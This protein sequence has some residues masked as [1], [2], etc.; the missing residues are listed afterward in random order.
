MQLPEEIRKSVFFV[1]YLTENGYKFAG[2]G[3]FVSMSLA[4]DP[5]RMFVYLITAKHVIV[6]ATRACIDGKIW[7][8]INTKN[9][10]E[11]VA[12]EETS[13]Q[14]HPED[15]SIDAAVLSWAPDSAYFDYLTI[16][17]SLIINEEVIS[18][19]GIGLG[20]EVFLIGLFVNHHGRKKNIPI[21][22]FGNIAAMPEEPIATRWFGDMEAYLI[23]ARSIGGLSGSPVFV[24]LPGVRVR[25]NGLGMGGRAFYWLGLMHGH[26]DL[27][28]LKEDMVVEDNI[29][30]EA[31]NMG[32]GIVV[33]ASKI[34]EIINS[35]FFM[36][37]RE[38]EISKL[39]GSLED[40]KMKALDVKIETA[41]ASK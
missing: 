31:V 28:V 13:W 16:P 41:Q 36:K 20:D 40:S 32:I 18:K 12:S 35:S 3:F 34:L 10:F 6:E 5:N 25:G 7:L 4:N 2:N 17:I 27:P 26:W 30:K 14:T 15:Y 23:E 24:Y 33:P 37:L 8:R 1:S 9:G 19:E 11:Y 38:A 22:R 39:C 21:A 29:S